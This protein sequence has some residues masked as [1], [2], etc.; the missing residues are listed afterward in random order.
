VAK[1][2]DTPEGAGTLLDSCAVLLLN[3]AGGG[4]SYENG[5]PWTAH[6]TDNMAMLVAGGAGGLRQGE[7]IVAPAGLAH[8]GNVIVTAMHAVGVEED[9]GEVSGVI[10]ELLG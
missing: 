9:F 2:H 3:E 1:L 8:P 5:I 4:V 6:S 7:H 10:P